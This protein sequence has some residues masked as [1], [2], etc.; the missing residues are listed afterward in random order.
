MNQKTNTP[1]HLEGLAE[2]LAA[3]QKSG[4]Q[5]PMVVR[6]AGHARCHQISGIYSITNIVNGKQYIGSSCNIYKRWNEHIRGLKG[7]LHPNRILQSSWLKYGPGSFVFCVLEMCSADILFALEQCFISKLKTHYRNFG[8]NICPVAK[9]CKG[10]KHT[11]ESRLKRKIASIVNKIPSSAYEALKDPDVQSKRLDGLRKARSSR[12]SRL[13]SSI[14]FKLRWSS[15]EYR[16][17]MRII[18]SRPDVV[19]RRT[20]SRSWYKAS[21]ETGI[22]ISL[23]NKGKKHSEESR[24]KMKDYNARPDVKA[25]KRAEMLA[26][27]ENPEYRDRL[28]KSSTGRKHSKET[29]EKMKASFNSPQ[30]KLK[31]SIAR[32]GRKHSPETIEKIRQKRIIRGSFISEETRLKMRMARLGKVMPESQRLKISLALSRRKTTSPA[33]P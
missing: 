29:I 21:K 9:S 17:K 16:E 25:R 12:R 22:K 24:Q 30:A 15:P 27:L 26:R 13:N 3:H 6:A 10:V 20:E 1:N 8:Y 32:T 7:N 4:H 11:A 18:N 2:S 33:N 19:K 5:E 14:A 31:R 23:A 28:S